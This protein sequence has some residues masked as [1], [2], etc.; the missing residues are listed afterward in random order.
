MYYKEL[1]CQSNFLNCTLYFIFLYKEQIK[2]LKS[3]FFKTWNAI[4]YLH[5]I[6]RYQF[7]NNAS[8]SLRWNDINVIKCD[9]NVHLGS[10]LWRLAYKSHVRIGEY[11]IQKIPS[12][13]N[14]RERERESPRSKN[15]FIQNAPAI[16]SRDTLQSISNI[17][18]RWSSILCVWPRVGFF[19]TSMRKKYFPPLIFHDYISRI[20]NRVEIPRLMGISQL[21]P[22]YEWTRSLNTRIIYKIAITWKIYMEH[23]FRKPMNLSLSLCEIL[24]PTIA[25]L[26]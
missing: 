17:H 7:W 25:S 5:Q 24:F 1:I 15:A 6:Y 20:F 16:L 10:R 4:L 19:S 9:G 23:D 13:F 2:Q 11:R 21:K 8:L 14:Q 3:S 22:S 18:F 12:L 26:K